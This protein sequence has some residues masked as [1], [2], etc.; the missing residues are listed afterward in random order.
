MKFKKAICLAAVTAMALS[1]QGSI[2]AA[3]S[4]FTGGSISGVT[5]STGV[6]AQR[7]VAPTLKMVTNDETAIAR[8]IK[9]EWAAVSNAKGYYYEISDK[10]DFSNIIADHGNKASERTGSYTTVGSTGAP[11]WG[12]AHKDYYVRVRT[13]YSNGT[14]AWSKTLKFAKQDKNWVVSVP[15]E[16]VPVLTMVKNDEGKCGRTIKF[17]WEK[18]PNAVKYYYEVSTKADFSDTVVSKE[19]TNLYGGYGT[20]GA[21]NVSWGPA[22]LDYYARVR[23]VYESR[24]GKWSETLMFPKADKEWGPSKEVIDALA[25]IDWSKVDFSGIK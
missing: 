16:V 24:D 2:L 17:E 23:A 25:G 14:S 8:T 11:T 7:K 9:F 21:G 18:I 15:E 12:P 3:P 5:S 10:S 19:T 20:S 1:V 22:H 6:Q 13:I 4:S